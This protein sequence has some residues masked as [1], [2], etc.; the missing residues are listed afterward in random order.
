MSDLFRKE[1][2]AH[3][4][5]TWLGEILL[6]RPT[7]IRLLGTLFLLS[8]LCLVGFLG[9]GQ[10]TK[11]VRVTGYVV[12]D[13]ELIR[14]LS[15]ATGT[16]AAILVADA[17][18]V[19]QDQALATLTAGQAGST[20][21]TVVRAPRDGVVTAIQAYPGQRS[22]ATQPLMRLIASDAH[23]RIDLYV[24]SRSIGFVKP[25]NIVQLRFQAFPYQKFGVHQGRVKSVSMTSVPASELA[26]PV[27]S[28]DPSRDAFY[29]VQVAMERGYVEAYGSHEPLLSGMAV[30]ADIWL[31]RRR[32]AEWILEPLFRHSRSMN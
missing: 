8:A 27:S 3:G 9:W 29:V 4:Q 32:L 10:Y 24:P 18:L 2:I 5:E 1:A 15:S 21:A 7:S 19:K 14:I 6:I 25:G 12:P 30:D 13:Q 31:D 28:H 23:L 26:F 20:P 11:K 17:E 22:F 16:L